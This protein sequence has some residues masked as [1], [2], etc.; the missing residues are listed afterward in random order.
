MSKTALLMREIFRIMISSCQGSLLGRGSLIQPVDMAVTSLLTMRDST[1]NTTAPSHPLVRTPNHR[2][3]LRPSA[4]HH[5]LSLG[6][7]T[8]QSLSSLTMPHLIYRHIL[9]T[10]CHFDFNE[11]FLICRV[12]SSRWVQYCL[13]DKWKKNNHS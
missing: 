4:M 8:H 2:T 9:F 13:P 6:G 12:L 10:K 5:C 3:F 1:P 11:N 7:T